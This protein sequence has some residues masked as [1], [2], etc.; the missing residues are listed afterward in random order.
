VKRYAILKYNRK[1]VVQ[2]IHACYITLYE[3]ENS[4]I[5]GVACR[6]DQGVLRAHFPNCEKKTIIVVMPAKDSWVLHWTDFRAL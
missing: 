6:L 5:Y 3:V 2:N 1:I 4:E